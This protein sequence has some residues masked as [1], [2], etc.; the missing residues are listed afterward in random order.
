MLFRSGRYCEDHENEADRL[1]TISRWREYNTKNEG[2]PD[3]E[4]H[5]CKREGCPDFQKT[6]SKSPVELTAPKR[7]NKEAVKLSLQR[8]GEDSRVGINDLNDFFFDDGME[9][10]I[11]VCNGGD[12]SVEGSTLW[13][14]SRTKKGPCQTVFLVILL[15]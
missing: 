7:A 1:A 2:D 13:I 12:D 10:R 5:L 3:F 15:R 6:A 8:F 4:K 14:I 9:Y 11:L